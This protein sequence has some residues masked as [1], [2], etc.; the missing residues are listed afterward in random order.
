MKLIAEQP[1][2]QL[3]ERHSSDEWRSFKLVGPPC[4]RKRNWW[5][6]HNGERFARN[7]DTGH[8]AEHLPVILD[9]VASAIAES[10]PTCVS[11]PAS[12][13]AT[14]LGVSLSADA[15]ADAGNDAHVNGPRQVLT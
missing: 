12:A 13:Q 3:F 11:V 14:P 5:L 7:H 2:W 1:G 8:L 4:R 9:W 10:Q 6:G 15:R